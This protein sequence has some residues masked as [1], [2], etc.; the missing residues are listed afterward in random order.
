M[1]SQIRS[2]CSP[3]WSK[4]PPTTVAPSPAHRPWVVG[5][6]HGGIR[7]GCHTAAAQLHSA[8]LG[9]ARPAVPTPPSSAF[10]PVRAR[11]VG[12]SE[13]E[14]TGACA[15][16]VHYC[17]GM[18]LAAAFQDSSCRCPTEPFRVFNAGPGKRQVDPL[19]GG[20]THAS[21]PL[22]ALVLRWMRER[23]RSPAI[24]SSLIILFER[25]SARRR[26]S[27]V[28]CVD[29]GVSVV[30]STDSSHLRIEPHVAGSR[31]GAEQG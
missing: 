27:L 28:G 11:H 30:T 4:Q 2:I 6:Q 26:H 8:K 9:T 19:Q 15:S 22:D 7:P 21:T 23:W 5:E 12:M 20:A 1:R 17:K 16:C 31:R 25:L 18:R 3:P 14:N 29:A 24:C 13:K 10:T